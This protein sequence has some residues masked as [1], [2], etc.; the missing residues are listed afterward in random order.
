MVTDI[1]YA[2]LPVADTDIADTI[3]CATLILA[4]ILLWNA[5]VVGH[6]YVHVWL[7]EQSF[8]SWSAM[9]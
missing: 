6:I 3:I 7:M 8:P 1:H 9:L 4:Y 5:I 2:I